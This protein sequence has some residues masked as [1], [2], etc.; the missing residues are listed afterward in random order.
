MFLKDI[1][2]MSV[3]PCVIVPDKIR[4]RAILSTDISEIMPYLNAIFKN[5]IYNHQ[6]KV[7]SL[8]K[9]ERLISL[10]PREL[11][12]AKALDN[13][14]ALE[15]VEWLKDLI[16]ETY[17][18]KDSITPLYERRSRPAPLV[19]YGWL[20]KASNCRLCGE[21]TCLAFATQLVTE[22]KQ[23]QDCPLIWDPGKEDMLESLK[24][25]LGVLI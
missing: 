19:I 25:L 16:N 1:K 12:V 5:A 9:D 17:A 6:G 10:Y 22:K 15:I 18:A 13:N 3:A 4:F 20:P 24:E 23:L 2:I 8:T 21:Q 7:L 11:T 14:D